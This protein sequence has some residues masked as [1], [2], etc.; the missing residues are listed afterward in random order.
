MET[1]QTPHD[2]RRDDVEDLVGAGPSERSE[3]E[4]QGVGRHSDGV[5]ESDRNCSLDDS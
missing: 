5:R 4:L 2:D 1:E 3:D